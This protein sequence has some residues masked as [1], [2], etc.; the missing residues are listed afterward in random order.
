MEKSV[1]YPLTRAQEGVVLLADMLQSIDSLQL[2]AHVDFRNEVDEALLVKAIHES[3]R[4]LPYCNV[5][6]CRDE[7]GKMVQ[8]MS[9]A[10]SVPVTTVE[11][12]EEDAARQDE[13]FR[14]WNQEFFP[15][16][17]ENQPLARFR[18]I[19]YADGH[20]GM[21]YVIQ[22]LVMDGYSG[23]KTLEYVCRV[24][25]A[26]LDGKELPK[27]VEEPWKLI[28]DDRAFRGSEHWQKQRDGYFDRYYATEPHF[29]SVNGLGSPEFVEGKAYG[30]RQQMTQFFGDTIHHPLAKDFV[31]RV[32]AAARSFNVSPQILYMLALRSYLGHVSG[33]DDV[34]VNGLLSSR[35][36]LYEKNCGMNLA[37]SHYVRTIIPESTRFSDAVAQVYKAQG[38][39]MRICK[40]INR[41]VLDLAYQRYD[42]PPDCYY[43]TTWLTYFPPV[44][45]PQDKLDLD[46]GFVSQGLIPTPLYLMIVPDSSRG[47]LCATYW[48]AVG[49]VEPENVEKLHAFMLR[50]LDE[51]AKAPEKS[52]GSLIEA[53]LA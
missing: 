17:I 52:I 51:A 47:T 35:G 27:P 48:Y 32:N 9:D 1:T 24:Y 16:T 8:Y 29:S 46:G 45:L 14:E 23:I 12:T 33:T 15:G 38:D 53:A 20:L 43:G 50:F 37:N 22:H 49:Y 26:M 10:E 30:K 21:Y 2:I 42:V 7:N 44:E 34:S 36:T 28:S 19:H 11:F 31:E 40:V 4:R 25:I 13:I 6:V 18:L 39:A 5:R 41:D 3:V